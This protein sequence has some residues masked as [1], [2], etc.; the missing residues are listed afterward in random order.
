M[1]VI[2]HLIAGWN[3]FAFLSRL[4]EKRTLIDY[5]IR[6]YIGYYFH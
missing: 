3:G 1:N 4:E 5:F 2:I 6:I